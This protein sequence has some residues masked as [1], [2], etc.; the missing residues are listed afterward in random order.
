MLSDARP[1]TSALLKTTVRAIAAAKSRAVRQMAEAAASAS[2]AMTSQ[3]GA[4]ASLPGTTGATTPTAAVV[5]PPTVWTSS[6]GAG[7]DPVFEAL[8][9]QR[10]LAVGAKAQRTASRGQ[11][12]GD[13][14]SQGVTNG[15]VEKR[16]GS[17]VQRGGRRSGRGWGGAG[18][19]DADR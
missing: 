10:R 14:S 19:G 18:R 13:A 2:E 7:S 12:Q 8:E 17:A 5:W 11:G 9:L 1:L 4:G 6:A 3:K 16:H 15:G